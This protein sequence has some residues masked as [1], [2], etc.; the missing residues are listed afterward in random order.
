M[1]PSNGQMVWK[2]S[3]YSSRV[4][5][6]RQNGGRESSILEA[7]SSWEAAGTQLLLTP[8][9]LGSNSS[10]L[11]VCLPQ[12]HSPKSAESRASWGTSDP[13][14]NL[15]A[16]GL[17][18]SALPHLPWWMDYRD[19]S[20]TVHCLKACVIHVIDPASYSQTESRC[21]STPLIKSKLCTGHVGQFSQPRKKGNP[22]FTP[23]C[24]W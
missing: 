12:H 13:R 11:R 14:S 18:P 23:K 10:P 20:L 15:E 24:Q 2:I 7:R 9:V 19:F 5:N 6:K 4:G 17:P 16:S 21:W 1:E 3:Y 22:S 8:H